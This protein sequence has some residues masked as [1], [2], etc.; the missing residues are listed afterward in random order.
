LFTLIKWS[1]SQKK[2]SK[3]TRKKFHE[4]GPCSWF[5]WHYF[6]APK[7]QSPQPP[8]KAKTA[9]SIFRKKNTNLPGGLARQIFDN[10]AELGS[11]ARRVSA[12]AAVTIG[13]SAAE[14]FRAIAAASTVALAVS[15]AAV[16]GELDAESAV[17]RKYITTIKLFI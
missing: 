12:T 2:V 5:F 6:N 10:Q 11:T 9:C 14:T 16:A 15:A 1:I 13:I 3:F 7:I 17:G 4:I 8:I